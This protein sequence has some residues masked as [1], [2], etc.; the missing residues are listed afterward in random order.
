MIISKY[1]KF[2][3]EEL[4]FKHTCN[5]LKCCYKINEKNVQ[6]DET[7]DKINNVTQFTLKFSGL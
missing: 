6:F 4:K 1:L 5:K 2:L 7:I 3:K